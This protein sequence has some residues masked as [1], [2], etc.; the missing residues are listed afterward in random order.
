MASA[1]A[2]TDLEASQDLPIILLGE[3]I[4][5]GPCDHIALDNVAAARAA[6]A[7]LLAIGR[8]RIAAI[9]LQDSPF[10]SAP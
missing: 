4:Y 8:R 3:R 2:L 7:H 6:T 10:C 9:G 1:A 5:G